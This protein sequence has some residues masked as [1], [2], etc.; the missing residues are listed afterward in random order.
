MTK[1]YRSR[2]D[3]KLF[4]L[5]GGLAEMIN[6]DAT[7]LRLVFVVTAFF[8]AG[9]MIAIY[10]IASLVIPK[11]PVFND[12]FFPSSPPVPSYPMGGTTTYT[13]AQPVQ[14]AA[15]DDLDEMMKS[16]EQKAMK[17]ELEE[18]RAKLAKYENEKG[19]V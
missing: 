11:E 1:L 4:G 10:I 9:T 8:S 12:P 5:C 17:K 16:I 13:K 15:K 7:L 14:Q 19:E 18:L 6:V 2:R 3:S